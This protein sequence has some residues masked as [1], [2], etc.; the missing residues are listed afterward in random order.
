M[1]MDVDHESEMNISRRELRVLLLHEFRLDHNATKAA[2]NICS[3]M[4]ADIVSIRTAQHWLHGLKNGH[5]DLDDL[6]HTERP[7]QVIEE[8]LR[9]TSRCLAERLQCSHTIVEKHLHQLGKMW[10]YGV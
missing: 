7:G 4:G 6:P 3:T 8:D 9:L 10:K 2:S 5:F 1:D